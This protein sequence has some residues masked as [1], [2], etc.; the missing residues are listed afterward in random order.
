MSTAWC[1]KGETLGPMAEGFGI[2]LDIEGTEQIAQS[3][4]LAF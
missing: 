1:S 4:G 2:E 3:H